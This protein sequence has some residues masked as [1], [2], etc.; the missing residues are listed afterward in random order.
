[1]AANRIGEIGE[2]ADAMDIVVK[3]VKF[4]SRLEILVFRAYR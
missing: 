1:M 3:L 2:A 4:F